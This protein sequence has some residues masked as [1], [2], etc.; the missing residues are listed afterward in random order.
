M[1]FEVHATPLF[2]YWGNV[3]NPIE[4]NRKQSM[5]LELENWTWSLHKDLYLESLICTDLDLTRCYGYCYFFDL[6]RELKLARN[7]ADQC[8]GNP[9]HHQFW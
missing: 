4:H 1:L 3:R 7:L 2:E 5:R 9:Y 8:K 6:A